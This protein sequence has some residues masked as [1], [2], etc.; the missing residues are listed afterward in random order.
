MTT[1]LNSFGASLGILAAGLIFAYA[2]WS[3]TSSVPWWRSCR[4]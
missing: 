2:N 3:S 1:L 4:G